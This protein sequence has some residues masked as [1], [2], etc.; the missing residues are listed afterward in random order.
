MVTRFI[1]HIYYIVSP[2]LTAELFL[3]TWLLTD[4]MQF[5]AYSAPAHSLFCQGSLFSLGSTAPWVLPGLFWSSLP[6][7]SQTDHFLP[8]VWGNW[9]WALQHTDSEPWAPLSI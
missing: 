8:K 3:K 6:E 5:Y 1:S 4:G 2:L 7:E 9:S